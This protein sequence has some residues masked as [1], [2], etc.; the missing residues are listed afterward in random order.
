MQF[1][2]LNIYIFHSFKAWIPDAI[3]SLKYLYLWKTETTRFELLL[4]RGDQL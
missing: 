1:L 4:Q 2:A 3:S